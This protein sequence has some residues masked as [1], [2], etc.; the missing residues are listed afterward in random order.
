[1]N[2]IWRHG[3]D[4]LATK[5]PRD[6]AAD[7]ELDLVVIGELLDKLLFG[8]GECQDPA[9]IGQYLIEQ[10]R[11]TKRHADQ[12][13]MLYSVVDAVRTSSMPVD[14]FWSPDVVDQI[15]LRPAS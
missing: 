12:V 13:A 8:T 1:M 5:T 7:E 6:E 14:C 10:H 2:T 4:L 9:E 15:R 3:L 11:W